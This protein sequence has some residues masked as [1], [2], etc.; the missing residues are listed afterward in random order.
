[1][2]TFGLL[3]ADKVDGEFELEIQHIKAIRTLFS[4]PESLIQ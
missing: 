1:M 4:R 2:S 3:L